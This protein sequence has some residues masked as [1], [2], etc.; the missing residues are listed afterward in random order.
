MIMMTGRRNEGWR[1]TRQW[2]KHEKKEKEK[3]EQM[4]NKRSGGDE[5]TKS[6]LVEKRNAIPS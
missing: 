4:K 3:K 1:N 5:A 2:R 6:I